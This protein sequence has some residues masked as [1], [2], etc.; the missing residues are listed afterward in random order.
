MQT[1]TSS[2]NHESLLDL[3]EMD[4]IDPI[5]IFK[6]ITKPSRLFSTGPDTSTPDTEEHEHT[7]LRRESGS[8]LEEELLIPGIAT[9]SNS[10]MLETNKSENEMLVSTPRIEVRM[11]KHRLPCSL[12]ILFFFWLYVIRSTKSSFYIIILN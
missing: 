12:P 5:D 7:Q 11:Q 6:D 3:F 1:T 8:T 10:S 9:S 2:G 4:E